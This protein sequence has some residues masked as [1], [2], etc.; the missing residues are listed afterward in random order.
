[1]GMKKKAYYVFIGCLMGISTFAQAD[2]LTGYDFDSGDT[3]GEAGS[4]LEANVLGANVTASDFGT[5]IGLKNVFDFTLAPTDALDAEGNA[6]GTANQFAFGGEGDAFGF[7]DVDDTNDLSGA[8]QDNDYMEFTVTPDSGYKVNLE[9]LTFRTYIRQLVNSAERW[10]LF[11]SIDGYASGVEIATGQ[12]TGVGTWDGA[13]NNVVVDLSDAKFQDVG[14]AVTFRLYVYGGGESTNSITLF[15]KVVLNGTAAKKAILVGYDFD[16]GASDQS[17]ATTVGDNLSASGLTSPMGIAFETAMGDSSGVA[18]DDEVF[19]NTNT[20]GALAISVDDTTASSFA[21]AVAGDDYVSFTVTPDDG[22]GFHL[23]QLSFKA[24]KE[25]AGSVDE[26]AVTDGAGIL[27]GSAAVITNVVGLTGAYDGVSIDL[28]GTEVEF[29]AEAT[30]FRIYAWGRGTSDTVNTLAAIDKVALYGESS[31]DSGRNS[32]FW[33]TLKPQAGTES[34]ADTDLV[35]A[36]GYRKVD[37]SSSELTCTRVDNGSNWEYQIRWAG[38]NLIDGA[39][40]EPLEFN[41]VVEAFSGA[42]YVYVVNDATVTSLGSASSPTDINNCWGVGA[43]FDFDPGESL[44]MTQQDFMV[45]GIDF[46]TAGLVLENDFT[47][48]TVIETAGGYGHQIIFGVG[49]NLSTASFQQPS[50]TYGISGDSFSVTGAGSTTGGR[51]F[52]ISQ[53]KF[54]FVVRN[55]AL[56]VE[57]PE[58]P[59]SDIVEVATPTPFEPTTP[60]KLA[61]AFPT[62]SWDRIPRTMLIRN[63]ST[64]FTDDEAR[65]IANRYDFVV[66]EKA[67]GSIQGYYEKATEL[68][69][70]NPNIKTVFYWNSRIF[71]GSFGIDAAIY[72]EDNWAAWISPTFFIRGWPTYERSNPDFVDWWAG[73]CH[74]IMGLV[75]GYASDGVT[76]FQDFENWEHGSP[77][78]GYFIDKTGVP[79]SMLQPLYEGSADW[80]FCMNNNGGNR[81][82]QPYLDGTY[83]EGY[84]GGGSPSAIATAIAISQ[85]SGKNQK[86][87]MLR[88]PPS[89]NANRRELEDTVDT[90]LA[91]Y[92]AYAEKYAYFY[93]QQTVDASNA[94]WQWITDYYDQFNRPLGA[95]LSDAI[96]DN[97]IYARSFERCD[98][99]LDLETDS[100]NKLSRIMWKNDIGSPALA[101]SGASSTDDTYTLEGSGNISD[102]A[103]NFFYLSDLHYGNGS[104]VARI[105]SLDNTHVDARAGIMFR[106]RNEPV[107]TYSDWAEDYTAA[108]SN[109]TILVSGARTVAVVRDPA[110]QMQMVYRSATNGTLQTAGTVD[111]AYG[112][113]AKLV[114]SGDTFTGTCS[115]DGES[116]TQIAQITLSMA[117]RV[118]MGMA[119]TSG[120]DTVLA[121]ATFSSFSRTE[122]TPNA[123]SQSVTTDEDVP[124]AITLTGSDSSDSNL[125][126]TVVTQPANG[127]LN[128]TAPNL[129]FTPDADYNGSDSFTFTVNDG[130]ADSDAAT[131]TITID[132]VEDPPYFGAQTASGAIAYDDTY[133]SSLAGFGVDPEGGAVTYSLLSGP[134]WLNITTNGTL[135][136]TP[137]ISDVGPNSW[138]IVATDENGATAT[139]TLHIA[140][141]DAVLIGYD[142]DTDA[143]DWSAAT[144]VAEH[145]SASSFTSPMDIAHVTGDGDSSGVDAAGVAFGSTS[146]L[147][148]VGVQVIDATTGSFDAAVAGNDYMSFTITPDVGKTV[149]LYAITFKVAMK[150]TTAVD[151]YALTDAAGNLIGTAS[152]ITNSSGISGTY[153]SVCVNLSGTSHRTITA[154][155]EFRIYA[156]G[157]GTTATSN[158]IAAFDKLTLYGSFGSNIAPIAD[159][160]S[161]WVNKN[162]P[163]AITLFGLDP[164]GSNITYDVVS[165][166]VNGTLSG[167]AP[168]LIYT[169]DTDYS[170]PDTFTYTVND[171]AATS[172]VATVSI[173]V[174]SVNDAPVADDQSITVGIN[175]A[176]AITLSGSDPEGSNLTY[177]VATE[178]I[179][180]TLSGS[181][182]D[183]IYT[184]TNGTVGIDSFTFSVSDGEFSSTPATVSITIAA[185]WTLIKIDDDINGWTQQGDGVGNNPVKDNLTADDSSA[186]WGVSNGADKQGL[187]Y[188][189]Y[190][191]I[192]GTNLPSTIQAGTYTLALRIGNGDAYDF[193]GLN[194]ISTNTNTE[195][196]AVAGFF[197]TVGA[198]AQASKNNMYT[199]FN[200]VSGVTY[201]APTEADPVDLTWTT[202]TFTWVIDAGSP[203]IGSNP[204]FGVYNRTGGTD[205]YGAAFF[206]DSILSYVPALIVNQA[207]VANTIVTSVDEDDSVSITLSGS[208]P[209][210]SNVTYSV[211]IQPTNGTLSGT[212]PD[213]TYTP[214]TNYF[215]MDSFAYEVDDGGLT[216]AEALVSIT[217]DPVNDAPVADDQ[218]VTVGLNS[219]V[220]ITLSGLDPDGSNLTYTVATDPTNGTLSGVVPDLTYV[221][222]TGFFGTDSFTYTVH[223][224]SLTSSIAT[225][226]IAVDSSSKGQI[227]YT[228]ETPGNISGTGSNIVYTAPDTNSFGNGVTV[229]S[230]ELSDNIDPNEDYGRIKDLGGSMEAAVNDRNGNTISFTV[231]M[232]ESVIVNLTNL[233]FDTSLFFYNDGDSTVGWDF[234]TVTDSG[235]NNVISSVGW[236]H[237]GEADYQSP[238]GAASGNIA[239]AGLTNLTDTSVT[240][241]WN[242]DSTRNNTFE[243]AAMGLDDVA[244]SGTVAPLSAEDSPVIDLEGAVISSGAEMALSWTAESGVSYILSATTNLVA[245]PWINVST[246]IAGANGTLSVTNDIIKDQQFFR[247]NLKK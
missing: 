120:D 61:Q 132:P 121:E 205:N 90:T 98:L 21:E 72:E 245:G 13:S 232:D 215:G 173:T 75:E 95:P 163:V 23:N 155:T 105:D 217:V 187:L 206:D 142:F 127:T 125:S 238:G 33:M 202:W 65:R 77:I 112:P 55:P 128:G 39:E 104:V 137:G 22:T 160:R 114:R 92:L 16:A 233:T 182:P 8:I 145:V 110:G 102:S 133:S 162:D 185:P 107:T 141:V 50:E 45:D 175:S 26:Y 85:E 12:T 18:A 41:V 48:M 15:D 147:G 117:E 154:A 74:K 43:D 209:E 242:L 96:K 70:Y 170:G 116:W 156:W 140:V 224:G 190:T 100:G 11:S 148:S 229:S 87:T 195:I 189:D 227:E 46:E 223:D 32:H 222:G 136:G 73:S 56:T 123:V 69:S 243:R 89:G 198:D 130:F 44:R 124:V 199:E 122:T 51:H 211:V 239:L 52:A 143:A 111:A 31:N 108:Y 184:P 226:S 220:V 81:T 103:D 29:I 138:S 7:D 188:E 119:V 235:T 60:E 94:D 207:P 194:D 167:T 135:S 131:V 153:Q 241:V 201:T 106:E 204:D 113:Y 62:F 247:I 2:I 144:V 208:D 169:P 86:L 88:N 236:T 6:F 64:S 84:T 66:L 79:T 49:T 76:A 115:S 38:N 214:D 159:A 171:G 176:V 91:Y 93:H 212:A 181:A 158:T 20:L 221:S 150:A 228:F 36:N 10:A 216:S 1:M 78:D 58:Y 25:S 149:N 183:L 191:S 118:E 210:G 19:G 180:G 97:Y 166:P 24:A 63:G 35:L 4:S 59:L 172:A 146:T 178:P 17:A 152:V 101:G 186:L 193:T 165:Y 157:R 203:V 53:V 151:E 28:T 14:E 200:E 234:Y 9:S 82:R 109:G 27:I 246:N 240:F 3:D 179:N 177:T 218:S 244:L 129:T 196:G 67:N 237:D 213:L 68:K 230:L 174:N 71:Y 161:V 139:G 126:F 57:D 80:S 168:D 134:S 83:W 47:S 34:G 37:L 40:A 99:Y 225:V 42:D 164:E 192:A 231:T 5:G 197:A 54:S 219:S 30:E